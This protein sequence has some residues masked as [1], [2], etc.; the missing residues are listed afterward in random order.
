MTDQNLVSKPAHKVQAEVHVG[1]RDSRIALLFIA[2]NRRSGT[3]DGGRRSTLAV[4]SASSRSTSPA[5][6]TSAQ[7]RPTRA[8]AHVDDS[9][10]GVGEKLQFAVGT[11][12]RE[13]KP[14]LQFID[15]TEL[16]EQTA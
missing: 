15:V 13:T 5:S 10:G 14:K 7:Q 9:S 6:V 12:D 16:F 1:R 11:N 3:S 8:A 4:Q 2:R